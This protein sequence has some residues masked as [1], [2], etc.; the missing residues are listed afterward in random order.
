MSNALTTLVPILDGSNYLIWAHQM[1]AFLQSME[2][3]EMT[4]NEIPFPLPVIPAGATQAPPADDAMIELQNQ[5]IKQSNHALGNM[6]LCLTPPIQE[7]ITNKSTPESWEYLA[8]TY[9]TP[10]LSTIYQDFHCAMNFC[11]DLA[12]HPGV[13]LQSS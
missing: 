2:L 11:L 8:M 7:Q 4:N 9:S 5:W 3:W 1:K 12:K 10:T 13:H 6:M